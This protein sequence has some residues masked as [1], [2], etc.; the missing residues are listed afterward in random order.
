MID[1]G[2][3]TADPQKVRADLA[4]IMACFREVLE[5]AGRADV[6]ACLPFGSGSEPE[7]PPAAH[8]LAQASSIAFRLLTLVDHNATAAYRRQTENEQ[9]LAAVPSLWAASLRDLRQHGITGDELRDGLRDVQVEIVLTAHPTEAKRATVLEHYRSLY[10]LLLRRDRAVT[11]S[12]EQA[13]R[14]KAKALLSLLWHT[15]DI[16]LAKPDIA[17]E[18]RNVVH[19]L[20]N[21]VPH[22]QPLVDERLRQAWSQEVPDAPAPDRSDMLPRFRAGTWV[23][24][25]RDGHPLVTAGVTRESLL[26][27][28]LH[29]LLLLHGQ[30]TQLVRTVSVSD[31][32]RP[33][34]ER[35]TA[36]IRETAALLGERGAEALARNPAESWRQL[37]GIMLERLPVDITHADHAALADGPG[38]YRSAT[39]LE[40]DLQLLHETLVEAGAARIARSAV[41]PVLRTVQ[42]FGFHLAVLDIRQ[43]SQFHDRALAQMLEAAGLDA[44]HFVDGDEATRRAVIERELAN[45]RPLL[46]AGESA[47]PEADAVLACYRVLREHIDRFGA[48]GLGSLIV[49]MTR[50]VSDLLI[51]YLFAREAGLVES[52]DGGFVCPLPVVPLFETIDDLRRSP[53]ILREFLAHPMTRRGLDALRRRQGT[54]SPV[55]QVMI[56]YSDSNKDGGIAASLWSLYRAQARLARTGAEAG[57]RVRFFHGRGGTISRG[58]GPTH[59]FIKSLPHGTLAGDLRL[60]EQGETIA[61][62]YG[63]RQTAAHNLE[64]LIAGAVRR[65]LLDRHV[66]DPEHP[67]EASLDRIAEHSLHVYTRLVQGD[68]FIDFFRQATPIDAIEQARIGSRPARRTGS[69]SLADLRAIPWVF[70]WAQSRFV[71]SG[72]FGLGSALEQFERDEPD[73]FRLMTSELLTWAPLHYL[74]SNA[75]TSVAVADP[76]IM[77]EYAAL[78]R[79]GAVR[80]RFIEPIVAEHDLTRRMLERVYGGPL[81]ERRP[82]IH[83]MTTLRASGLL[84]LHRR[85]VRLLAEWRAR[86]G[87]TEYL[88]RELLLVINAISA[89]LGT[90]G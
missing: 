35:L 61:Q 41:E 59:R 68:G 34:P 4:W 32:L 24:G 43:N 31:L 73:A 63:N 62:K 5:E 1:I 53:A 11:A 28:R 42:S 16:F 88:E 47:G 70:S 23:G 46:R 87:D 76:A 36:R 48:D 72:W 64:L 33:P 12:E 21:I 3:L 86:A 15:G 52:D 90:T 81:S 38:R 30:L 29:A 13:I 7:L 75:A 71:L 25:D 57:V 83:A 26:D 74:I 19:Y 51:V 89:G 82:N 56:G 6:A 84:R 37:T 80:E 18:R 58:A 8:E 65:T 22:V 69:R 14:E 49:S 85:Q 78:V 60:T 39:E 66:A 10:I 9:G 44:A 54:E 40:A 45:P 20:K 27:M 17:A 67:L 2:I 50:D 77:R 55:Q 79:D